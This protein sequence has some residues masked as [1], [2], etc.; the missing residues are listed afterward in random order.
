MDISAISFPVLFLLLKLFAKVY[1]ISWITPAMLKL[2]RWP[3]LLL[4]AIISFNFGVKSL[5]NCLSEWKQ[6]GKGEHGEE[7]T[8]EGLGEDKVCK[9]SKE[10]EVPFSTILD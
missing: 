2:C 6:L 5:G 10:K 8:S 4:A 3:N 9:A 1:L 7:K